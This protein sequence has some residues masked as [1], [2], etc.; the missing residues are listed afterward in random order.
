MER[1][2]ASWGGRVVASFQQYAKVRSP[3][4]SPCSDVTKISSRYIRSHFASPFT[5]HF[6][7]V[8]PKWTPPSRISNFRMRQK[9]RLSTFFEGEFPDKSLFWWEE[10]GGT[11]SREV[12]CRFCCSP[13]KNIAAVSGCL[14]RVRR[15]LTL[16]YVILRL[17]SK[18]HIP[19]SPP[20]LKNQKVIE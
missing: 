14:L 7:L 9:V 1:R 15:T 6:T 11:R 19:P 12:V 17:G 18:L 8:S 2:N 13:A 3:L 20:L 5:F 4:N 16:G 10:E